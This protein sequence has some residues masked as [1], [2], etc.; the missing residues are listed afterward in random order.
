MLSGG[1]DSCTNHSNNYNS[2]HRHNFIQDDDQ[3]EKL[4]A[5]LSHNDADSRK[6]EISES[7]GNHKH[8]DC[9]FRCSCLG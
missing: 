4:A 2:E 1:D 3:M 7:E 9:Y 6:G 8:G 5:I